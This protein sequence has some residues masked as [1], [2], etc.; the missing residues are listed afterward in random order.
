MRRSALLT[1]VATLVAL[2]LAAPALSW[3]WPASG[4]VVRAFSL[5]DDPYAGGQHRGID[6][7][8][9]AGSDVL[10]PAAGTVSF[11]GTVP[12]NGKTVTIQTADGYAVEN[13]AG[14]YGFRSSE[15]LRDGD[16]GFSVYVSALAHAG[17]WLPIGHVQ[18]FALALRLY[19]TPLAASAGGIEKSS[20]P[21]IQ[22]ESCA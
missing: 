17:N 20:V 13:A 5:G 16:G 15:I 14:R 19:D 4:P 22:R 2:I 3:T 7:A 6:I 9:V 12:T 18:L 21:T 11:A 10:A 1:L 8:G